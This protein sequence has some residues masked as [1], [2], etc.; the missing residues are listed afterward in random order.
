MKYMG[1]KNKYSKYIVPIIQKAIN[2]N[3]VNLYIEP[4]VGGANL[5]DKI[6]CNKRIGY[7]KNKYL[8][9]LLNQAK[10]DFKKIPK[11][12]SKEEFEYA[13][14]LYKKQ[15][16]DELMDESII[17]AY[18]F[19]GSYNSGGFIKG[20]AKSS[21]KRKYYQEAYNN[22]YKQHEKLKNIEFKVKDY[23]TIIPSDYNNVCFY[24]DP[25]YQNVTK[26]GYSFENKFD[27]NFFW[28]WV[29]ELSKNNIVFISENSA[30]DD[31][32]TIWKKDVIYQMNSGGNG[33]RKKNTE[34]LFIKA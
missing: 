5:I 17:G 2:D 25:P 22:L 28:D 26:Y 4:F 33:P 15:T 32:K 9:A 12:C 24:L 1:S 13:K 18:C 16:S 11:T 29:R 8:I 19:L 10:N 21:E 30:P 23:T 6:D 34:K 20:Y 3:D 27:Y 7:D 14:E 31:F